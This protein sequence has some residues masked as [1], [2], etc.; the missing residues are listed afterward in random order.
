MS[1]PTD[2]NPRSL[3]YCR[4]L[5]SANSCVSLGPGSLMAC[6]FWA[7]RDWLCLIYHVFQ[8]RLTILYIRRLIAKN[9]S[10]LYR[11]RIATTYRLHHF[12]LTLIHW[13]GTAP[14]HNSVE[15][16]Q[17]LIEFSSVFGNP[18][19]LLPKRAHDHRILWQ[20]TA[21]LVN[22]C[23][24]RYPCYQ[25]SEIKHL[26]NELLQARLIRPSSSIFSSLIFLVKKADEEWLFC[27][28]YRAL[29]QLTIKDKF[30]IPVIDVLVSFM[31]Q[32]FSWNWISKPSI[33]R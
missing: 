12:S 2:P 3:N 24:Y 32:D 28:D 10:S 25:K 22:V 33:I 18:T 14:L 21:E 20:E 23:P 15:L 29:N 8:T 13:S 11:I 7:Y 9:E 17:L 27:V 19:T 30:S 5:R 26:M 1:I 6:Y 31:V 16:D 4:F